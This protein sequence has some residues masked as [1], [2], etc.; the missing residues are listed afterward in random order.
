MTVSDTAPRP[1]HVAL[2]NPF[3]WP[4]VR[5]GSERM[6]QLMS[7]GLAARG[8]RVTVFASAPEPGH[9]RRGAV[10]YELL[11]Q[12]PLLG[13]RQLNVCHAFAWA[14][15]PRLA[16]AD[17]DVVW[18]LS[19]FDAWAAVRA[20]GLGA[21]HRVIYHSMGIPV[22]A[23]FRAVP[24]DAWFMRSALRGADRRLVL[25]R[26]AQQ[27]LQAEFG[28]GAEVLPGIVGDASFQAPEGAAGT[29]QTLL[30]VGD[31]DEPRKGAALACA[32]WAR[33]RQRHPGLSLVFS[34]PASDATREC[35]AATP[36]LDGA[37]PTFLGL[38][39]VDD[40]PALYA[41]A[42]VTLLPAVW[43][44]FGLVLLESL[45]AGTPVVGAAHAGIV[46]IVDPAQPALGALFDP[47]STGRAADNLEGLVAAIEAVLVGGK[48]PARQAACIERARAFAW[49][50]LAPRYVAMAEGL[51]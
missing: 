29:T 42:S 36:G 6:L 51:A 26:F 46:D 25:S 19:H 43:E 40:L 22:R 8:H 3:C 47:G 44:A 37:R 20:R 11:P 35:L 10:D 15:A 50:A 45:A 34:G 27:R 28:V 2:A 38:G 17:A 13:R 49:R 33:L 4:W 21:R 5:R 9:E 48:P 30:F 32:A 14:L 31:A 18:C 12:R 1:L 39:R 7:E 24:V 41:Q 23:Y 16:T